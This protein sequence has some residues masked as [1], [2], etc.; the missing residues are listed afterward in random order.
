[1]TENLDKISAIFARVEKSGKGRINLISGNSMGGASA[2]Y[3]AARLATTAGQDY[4]PAPMVLLDPQ[5]LN[6]RHANHAVRSAKN[7]FAFDC[8]RGIAITLDS[9]TKPKKNLIGKMKSYAGYRHPGLLELKMPTL[10]D[11]AVR[12]IAEKDAHGNPALHR[13]KQDPRPMFGM[14][15]HVDFNMGLSIY[16]I[17]LSRFVGQATQ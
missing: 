17:A 5:L 8:P 2:Q 3:V 12:L 7:G 16:E 10:P 11:D 6:K 15:Y 13:V 1:L 4:T 9:P 14:G